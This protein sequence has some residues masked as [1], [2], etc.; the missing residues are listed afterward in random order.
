MLNFFTAKNTLMELNRQHGMIENGPEHVALSKNTSLALRQQINSVKKLDPDTANEIMTLVLNMILVDDDKNAVIAAINGKICMVV[1]AETSGGAVE[2]CPTPKQECPYPELFLSGAVWEVLQD[3]TSSIDDRLGAMVFHFLSIGLW[4]P[5][6]TAVKNIVSVVLHDQAGNLRDRGL[7][8][9]KKFKHAIVTHRGKRTRIHALPDDKAWEACPQDFWEKYSEWVGDRE[10]V[11]CQID[12]ERIEWLKIELGCRT[13]KS[14]SNRKAHQALALQAQHYAR[15]PAIMPTNEQLQQMWLANQYQQRIAQKKQQQGDEIPIQFFSPQQKAQRALPGASAQGVGSTSSQ[16]S[17]S[18]TD[19]LEMAAYSNPAQIQ[20]ATFGHKWSTE[21]LSPGAPPSA[22]GGLPFN[23]ASG[24]PLSSA[25]GLPPNFTGGLPPNSAG[26]LPPSAAGG[27][28]SR[29]AAAAQLFEFPNGGQE[30][31]GA[32]QADPRG[33]KM[34][35]ALGG[36]LPRAEPART[37]SAAIPAGMVAQLQ[38]LMG[39]KR[40]EPDASGGEEKGV[41]GADTGSPPRRARKPVDEKAGPA[42][43]PKRLWG[44]KKR[45]A[46]SPAVAAAAKATAGRAKEVAAGRPKKVAAGRTEKKLPPGWKLE[47]RTRKSGASAGNVDTYYIAPGG[48]VVDSWKK[49]LKKIAKLS[50][51]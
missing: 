8:L 46:A 23:S 44:V 41:Q 34:P 31:A 20:Q 2:A 19:S 13:T 45:P 27:L 26:G 39:N 47:Y 3:P 18:Q 16:A 32:S 24:L 9:N 36:E 11:A 50:R 17:D 42:G 43:S 4:Y 22:Q 5:T 48:D 51:S 35:P 30:A 40:K 10:I 33:F 15:V 12:T 6:E 25:G 38:E 37:G 29:Q 1:E 28:P 7:T 21:P 49:V 14:G